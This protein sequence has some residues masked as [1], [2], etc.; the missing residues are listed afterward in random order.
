M[1]LIALRDMGYLVLLIFHSVGW[2]VWFWFGF[3][4]TL[5]S[6]L[7]PFALGRERIRL[8]N[9]ALLLQL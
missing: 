7:S 8:E 4:F 5:G 6:L 1:W 9:Y 2:F 3:V